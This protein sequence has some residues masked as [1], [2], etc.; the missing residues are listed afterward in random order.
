MT[1]LQFITPANTNII[2]DTFFL[3]GTDSDG[4][5]FCTL[6][7]TDMSA[8]TDET[9]ADDLIAAVNAA[10]GSNWVVIGGDAG[11]EDELGDFA[12]NVLVERAPAHNPHNL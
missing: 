3:Y 4:N 8:C 2:D 7:T 5:D 6:L 10:T 11:G 12:H 1:Y 9:E